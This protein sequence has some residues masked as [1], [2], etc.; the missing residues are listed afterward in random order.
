VAQALDAVEGA[1]FGA[2]VESWMHVEIDRQGGEAD[3]QE[4]AEALRRVL[5]DV[6][7]TVEDW[8][9]IKLECQRIATGLETDPPKGVDPEEV[10]H[11]RRLM[12]WLADG[13]FTFI[14][15]REYSLEREHAEDVLRALPSTGLGILRYDQPHS[16]SFGR[17]SKEA[18]AKVREPH[19]LILTKANAR[20]TVHRSSHLDYVGIKQFDADGVVTGEKRFLG[21]FTANAY[22]ESVLRVPI[23]DTLVQQVLA[24]SGFTA[25]S[26]SGKDLLDVIENYPRDEL[27]QT[28]ADELYEIATAVL[29]SQ[30]RRKSQLFMRRDEYGRFVSCVIYI[31]RD[32]YTTAVRLKMDAILR[33]AFHGASVDYTTRVSESVLARLHFVV[34]VAP[35][36]TVPVV[37][38]QDLQ[39]RLI[40]ATRTWDEDL[41]EVAR[42]EYGEEVGARLVGLYGK[43]FPEAYKEDFSPRVGVVDLRQFEVLDSDDAIRLNLYHEPGTPAAERRFK[44]YRRGSLSLTAVLPLF[45]DFGLEVVDERPYRIDRADGVTVH[46]YDFGLRGASPQT[47]VG[48][49][50]EG[51][52]E[53][54]HDAFA[55]VWDGRAES[56]GFNGLVLG[57][58]FLLEKRLMV[59]GMSEV[60]VSFRS[61][62]SDFATR[63]S[64]PVASASAIHKATKLPST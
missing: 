22:T 42:S 19:L 20:S 59:G 61:A 57:G 49:R 27:F 21:L 14:G 24:T 39:Q 3:E 4:L 18:R 56:D 13:H 41:S 6:R 17:L 26:H 51:L 28:T 46:V 40:D 37:D 44:L 15:F 36:Q 52:R 9:K 45:T 54:F 31:P 50:R 62:I 34:R 47:W 11:T 53:L 8:P 43:A 23:I 30:E 1:G 32:R 35:G 12:L 55:A 48:S 16:G 29:H 10:V 7:V 33:S 25:D 38:E 58:D 63:V 60:S 2:G 5:A 64:C